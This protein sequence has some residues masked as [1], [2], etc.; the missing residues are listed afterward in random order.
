MSVVLQEAVREALKGLGG[1][2]HRNAVTAALDAAASLRC[3]RTFS[4]YEGMARLPLLC[5]RFHRHGC[6]MA[7]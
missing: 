4:T 1:S 2:A 6:L 7:T 5:S 3:C